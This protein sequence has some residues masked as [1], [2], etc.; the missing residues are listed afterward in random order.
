MHEHVITMEA[1]NE[2]REAASSHSESQCF[3]HPFEISLICRNA[4]MKAFVYATSSTA[5][6]YASFVYLTAQLSLNKL[7][8]KRA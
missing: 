6:E 4:T 3:A 8:V 7:L 5:V 2:M 1:D